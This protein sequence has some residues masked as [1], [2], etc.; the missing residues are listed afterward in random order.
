[1]RGD[2]DG[3]DGLQKLS[4][5]T[6]PERGWHEDGLQSLQGSLFL[7]GKVGRTLNAVGRRGRKGLW[8]GDLAGASAGPDLK[9]SNPPTKLSLSAQ[10]Q[11]VTAKIQER[12]T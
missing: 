9:K 3:D 11:A 2:F 1:M 12:S 8:R 7:D 6:A 10:A 4:G 5:A